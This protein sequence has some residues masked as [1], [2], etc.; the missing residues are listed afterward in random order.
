MVLVLHNILQIYPQC[1]IV[2]INF[3]RA[4]NCSECRVFNRIFFKPGEASGDDAN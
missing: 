4:T 3:N 2:P 1:I